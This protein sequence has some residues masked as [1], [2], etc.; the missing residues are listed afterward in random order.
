[1]RVDES[2]DRAEV[3]AYRKIDTRPL[4][5]IIAQLARGLIAEGCERGNW[6][7]ARGTG[8]ALLAL[9]EVLDE[10]AF[11]SLR[12][13][14][15]EFLAASATRGDAGASWGEEVWDSAIALTALCRSSCPDSGMISDGARWLLDVYQ[16]GDGNW[17]S[18][19]WESHWA[20]VA[21]HDVRVASPEATRGFDPKPALNWLLSLFDASTGRLV[22]LHYTAQ[23]LIASSRWLDQPVMVEPSGEL[24]ERLQAARITASSNLLKAMRADGALWSA[25]LWANSLIVWGL[26]DAGAAPLDQAWIDEIARGFRKAIQREQPTEDR[27]FAI[28]ALSRLATSLAGAAAFSL[29]LGLLDLE[30]RYPHPAVRVMLEQ[31]RANQLTQDSAAFRSRITTQ[32]GSIPDFLHRPPA[33]SKETFRGYYTVNLRESVVNI[34]AVLIATVLLTALSSTATS[35]LDSDYAALLTAIP[36]GLGVLATLAQILDIRPSQWLRKGGT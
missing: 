10:G 13:S 3:A 6:E 21:M 20:L 15:C 1:M 9:A 24:A 7:D 17:Y 11:P 36:I 33:I 28:L 8:D 12:R 23:F 18:E 34:A 16:K 4:E 22:N 29:P 5:E 32:I 2:D 14:A 31:V 27:A 30:K 26:A 19:P 35:Y 25:E